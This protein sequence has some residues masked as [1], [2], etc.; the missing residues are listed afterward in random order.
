MSNQPFDAEHYVREHHAAVRRLTDAYGYN[1]AEEHD[2]C[3][4][5][6]IV[7]L[8]GK[9]TFNTDSPASTATGRAP[10]KRAESIIAPEFRI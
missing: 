7:A 4:V 3:G 6:L 9:P 2:S 10:S 5:G 8:D 1:P